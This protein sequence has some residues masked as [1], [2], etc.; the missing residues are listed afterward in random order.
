[1]VIFCTVYI[2]NTVQAMEK[3]NGNMMMIRLPPQPTP[4]DMNLIF[5][6][7]SKLRNA[8]N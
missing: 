8:V 2:N 6:P 3:S 4:L 1:M 7:C 5:Y